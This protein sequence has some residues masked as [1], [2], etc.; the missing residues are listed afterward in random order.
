MHKLFLILFLGLVS[1]S[2]AEG[3]S[4]WQKFTNFFNPSPTLEGEGP[5]YDELKHLDE[6]IKKTEAK[7]SRERR[8][9]NKDR[10]R[11]ELTELNKQRDDLVKK[12][13]E[14]ENKPKSSS[15]VVAKVLSSA[16]TPKSSS[17]PIPLVTP[18]K[19]LCDTLVVHD[20]VY[21]RDTIVVHDTLYVV[22]TNKPNQEPPQDSTENHATTSSP[23]P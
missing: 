17:T 7:Y 4:L 14:E 10:L 1:L 18:K 23:K 5:L 11:K 6:K 21:V 13:Q 9:G 20:T 22:L 8:P 19:K 12:I 2:M 3:P 15:S 16:Q